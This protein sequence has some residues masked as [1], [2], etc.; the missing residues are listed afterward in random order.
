MSKFA[1]EFVEQYGTVGNLKR[2][3]KQLRKQKLKDKCTLKTKKTK[4]GTTL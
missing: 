2:I 1:Y 4:L 3:T